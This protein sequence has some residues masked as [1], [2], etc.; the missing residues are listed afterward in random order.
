MLITGSGVV[1]II[2]DGAGGSG[3]AVEAADTA[4]MWTKAFLD[5]PNVRDDPWVDLL[6]RIDQQINLDNGETTAVVI[7][8]SNEKISGASVGDSVAWIISDESVDD[9]TAN[10]IRKPLL[11][12]GAAV[13]IG[14]ERSGWTGT[15][16]LASDGLINYAPRQRLWE[17]ARG[18][19]LE[20]AA[21]QL[22]DLVRLRSGALQD[23]TSIILCRRLPA[24][25]DMSTS[26]KRF[27][28]HDGDLLG[29][30]ESAE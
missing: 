17:I 18:P 23:D 26:R 7:S 14:F 22:I 4:I 3:G 9:L 1:G 21:R 27:S 25:K 10:Q 20:L 6:K 8:I 24:L 28:L 19:D 12:S 30:E 2:A 11:G 13:P 5:R 16:L 15:I 29:S